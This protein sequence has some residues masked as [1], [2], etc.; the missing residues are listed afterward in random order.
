MGKLLIKNKFAVVPNDLLIRQDISL[1][2]KGL[3]AYLQSKP[4]NWNFSKKRIASQL[5]EGELAISE[6]MKELK[7]A[8]YLKTKPVKDNTGKYNGHDYILY[9]EPAIEKT[10]TP[11][12][13]PLENRPCFSNKDYSKKEYNN[14]ISCNSS[15]EDDFQIKIEQMKTDKNQLIQIISYYIEFKKIELTSKEKIQSII[16]RNLRTAKLLKPYPINR[17][18]ETMKYLEKN[19]NYKWTLETAL[20]FIDEDLEDLRFRQ[21]TD[22]EKEIY[23]LNK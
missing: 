7:K 18:I 6:A 8:G 12:T 11:K 4:D 17:I 9:A 1:K 23:I 3:Y 5:K 14:N 15:C 13:D 2:A 10:T 16:K 21:M 19:A 20:K 22:K